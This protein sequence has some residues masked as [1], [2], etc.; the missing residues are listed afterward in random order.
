MEANRQRARYRDVTARLAT[1][2]NLVPDAHLAGVAAAARSQ[3][4][5]HRDQ[6]F[7]KFDLLDVRDPVA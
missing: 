6:H 1:R 3:D 4:A 2:G 5:L 7:R